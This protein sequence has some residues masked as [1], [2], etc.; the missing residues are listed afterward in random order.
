MSAARV[1]TVVRGGQIVTASDVFEAAVA[2]KGDR[3]VAIGPDHLFAPREN[4]QNS[5]AMLRAV[6]VAVQLHR[7][8]SAHS[9]LAGSK[10][11]LGVDIE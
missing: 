6:A 3:I 2:I 7:G 8:P 1:D 5:L 10:P 4:D 11:M 9:A